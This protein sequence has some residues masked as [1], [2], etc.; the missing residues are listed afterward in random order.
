M[1]DTTGYRR[2]TC[3]S[4]ARCFLRLSSVSWSWTALSERMYLMILSSTAVC[5]HGDAVYEPCSSCSKRV[6]GKAKALLRGDHSICYFLKSINHLV[7]SQHYGKMIQYLYCHCSP[8]DLWNVKKLL[9]S[10]QR[11]SVLGL[12]TDM[13]ELWS[14]R[15]RPWPCILKLVFISI[16]DYLLLLMQIA[17]TYTEVD[18]LLTGAIII[19]SRRPRRTKRNNIA[20][21][22]R[23]R[24]IFLQN[25]LILV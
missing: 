6:F 8:N 13:C 14:T 19:S 11:Y 20:D 16:P 23:C 3:A 25:I 21:I 17:K 24:H 22:L 5:C 12:S 4:R 15:P 7:L 18:T 9:K 1:S 2:K 10:P